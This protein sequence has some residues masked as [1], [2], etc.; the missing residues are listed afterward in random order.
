[1]LPF[2]CFIVVCFIVRKPTIDI[3]NSNEFKIESFSDS[4]IQGKTSCAITKSNYE[5]TVN[6]VL[7]K[8]YKFPYAGVQI[9]R[10]DTLLFDLTDYIL[11]IDIDAKQDMRMSIR[12]NQFIPDY[13]DLKNSLTLLLYS[14]TIGFKQGK[15]SLHVNSNEINEI[16]EWWFSLNPKKINDVKTFSSKRT[17][18]MWIYSENS[19]P[20][21]TPI[22][23]TIKK[24]KLVYNVIPLLELFLLISLVY[25]ITILIFWKFRKQTINYILMPIEHIKIP[26]KNSKVQSEILSFIATN[27][28]NPQLKL[29]DVSKVVGVSDDIISEV[30]KQYCNTN[31][32]QYINKIRME[33]AKRMLRETQLQISEIAFAVGYNNIQH[34][35]RVFKE[36]TSFSPKNFREQ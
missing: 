1:M 19:I 5:Y 14:K 2:F 33:E 15:N 9:N 12:F 20:L 23:F 27:Y 4:L 3:C 34:F 31:F 35:N 22:S 21:N 17:Q 11:Q 13:S 30:L 18:A 7:R 24:F 36:Y 16:P 26:E 32:R 8:G 25:Y 6:F 10:Y 28:Q 29:A